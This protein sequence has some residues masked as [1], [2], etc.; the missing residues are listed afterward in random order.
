MLLVDAA[1]IE[2]G[3]FQAWCG[4]ALICAAGWFFFFVSRRIVKMSPEMSSSSSP[5][6]PSSDVF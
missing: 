1:G 2:V 4:V 6:L 3:F 5:L